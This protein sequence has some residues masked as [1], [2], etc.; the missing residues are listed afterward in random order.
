MFFHPAGDL[1]RPEDGRVYLE[2]PAAALG[3]G[4]RR[5]AP[6]RPGEALREGRVQAVAQDTELKGVEELVDRVA[7]PRRGRE[8]PRGGADRLRRQVADER[9][10]LAVAQDVAEVL[11]Q[12]IARL[13]LD[14][15]DPVD[16]VLE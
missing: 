6:L 12:G 13:A 3:G 15:V 8:V 16:E 9:G 14:L 1:V 2:N 11:A 4:G 7:A 10:Q 5:G